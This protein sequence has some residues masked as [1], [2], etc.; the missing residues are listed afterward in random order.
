M[1][2]SCGVR[3]V[4]AAGSSRGV[5]RADAPQRHNGAVS[6]RSVVLGLVALL[7][8]PAPL[9]ACVADCNADRRVEIA[10]IVSAVRI[11]LDELPL[12]ACAPADGDGDQRV[13]IDELLAAVATALNAPLCAPAVSPSPRPTPTASPLP[14]AER[15]VNLQTAGSQRHPDLALI[16][17]GGALVVWS[18]PSG[19]SEGTRI[20]VRRIDAAGEPGAEEITLSD[21]DA[22]D[23]RPRIAALAGGGF[24]V[25]WERAVAGRSDIRLRLLDAS[26]QP[27][28]PSQRVPTASL[29]RQER[30]AI[31]AASDGGFLVAWQA[32][33]STDGSRRDDVLVRAF[34]GDGR[35]RGDERRVNERPP[36]DHWQH[37]PDLSAAADGRLL[38]V[39][40]RS[41]FG[42]SARG[43]GARWLDEMGAPLSDELAVQDHTAIVNEAPAVVVGANG[44]PLVLWSRRDDGMANTRLIVSRDGIV[45]PFL[46]GTEAQS[47]SA[48][49]VGG[50]TVVAA[51]QAFATDDDRWDAYARYLT[52]DGGE[53]FR[54]HDHTASSQ[55]APRIALAADGALFA[56]WQSF[57]QDRSGY[58]IYARVFK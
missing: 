14:V 43:I 22:D 10:E 6:P 38:A 52:P 48:L 57:G 47:G 24:A 56:V 20:I 35:P 46:D 18:G 40:A 17:G 44:E 25:T 1:V 58:G 21:G 37:E 26:G 19:T 53:V 49:A 12:A 54:L 39:W 55:E 11:A 29:R 27:S 50:G 8:L 7:L 36:L 23:A 9:R 42:S 41:T 31:A 5:S 45:G 16:A 13:A 3:R 51:W 2:A 28:A 4:S 32:D 15:R 34:E 30:P 33:D